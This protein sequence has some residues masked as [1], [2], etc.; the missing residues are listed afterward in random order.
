[1]PAYNDKN[2]SNKELWEAAQDLSNGNPTKTNKLIDLS[3]NLKT[4]TQWD[5]DIKM[6]SNPILKKSLNW[7]NAERIRSPNSN[8][9]TMLENVNQI[10]N[11]ICFLDVID[12]GNDFK[13]CKG[14]EGTGKENTGLL[15]S[16]IW[17]PLQTFI[18]ISSRAIV[19][20][21]KPLYSIHAPIDLVNL[22]RQERLAVPLSNNGDVTRLMITMTSQNKDTA[23]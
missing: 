9:K 10:I 21:N 14:N 22:P 13:Y 1:M 18:M 3:E 4:T 7:Y 2:P 17:T 20:K 6:I 5:P 19:I 8:R 16:N 23:H 12:Q 15:L 11:N